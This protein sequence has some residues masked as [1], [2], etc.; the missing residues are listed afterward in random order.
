MKVVQK[1]STKIVLEIQNDE[2]IKDGFDSVWDKIRDWY[3][4]DKY[5]IFSVTE[6]KEKDGTFFIELKIKFVDD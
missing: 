2:I 4:A 6:D 1:T 5:E 3:S